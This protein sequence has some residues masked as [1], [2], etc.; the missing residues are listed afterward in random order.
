M[1]EIVDVKKR[2]LKGIVTS[3]KMDKTVIVLVNRTKINP[4]YNKRYQVSKKYFADDPKNEYHIGDK[5]TISEGR[6]MSKRKRWIVANK[7]NKAE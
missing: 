6:P 1:T 7:F 3:D 2:I 4:L 5:V